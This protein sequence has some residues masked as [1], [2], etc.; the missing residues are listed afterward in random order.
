MERRPLS[1]ERANLIVQFHLQG[2]SQ[3]EIA[4]ALNIAPSVVCRA[5]QRYREFGTA[6]RR[7]GGGNFRRTT[8]RE[9]RLVRM[10]ARR[11]PF[12]TARQLQN[13]LF[14]S[15][16]TQ[17][18]DQTIRNRLREV[19]L[20]SYRPVRRPS[21]DTRHRRARLEWVN[22]RLRENQNWE[23]VLFS[24]ESRFCL[25]SDS[26]R[27]R[28]WRRP[29]T[30]FEPQFIQPVTAHRGGG[31]MVWGGITL[32][33]RTELHIIQGTLNGIRY[34]DDIIRG[35]VSDF[36][37]NIGPQFVFLDDNARPHRAR[38]VLEEIRRLGI[39]HLPLPALSPDLNP[40]EHIWD[41]LQRR[42]NNHQPQPR[43]TGELANVLTLLWE[44]IPQEE[45]AAVILSMANRCSAVQRV[46]GGYTRY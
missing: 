35:F 15:S 13:R 9:D 3:L 23:F 40:I 7:H 28:V 29:N 44:E 46:R 38:C 5:L 37:D 45:I 32:N 4:N 27:L 16:G 42:L 12:L 14:E 17:V 10:N 2:L 43:N 11:N 26:R 1:D 20:R 39:T 36:R 33:N 24:D 31:V 25:S 34:R 22:S 30:R 41:N 21:L 6:Q 18:S 19:G 8:E